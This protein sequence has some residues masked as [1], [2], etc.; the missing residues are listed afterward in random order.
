MDACAVRN[1][2]FRQ[3]TQRCT[4]DKVQVDSSIVARGRGLFAITT[5]HAGDT[6]FEEYPIGGTAIPYFEKRES[7]CANCVRPLGTQRF[8]CSLN[9]DES[10][11][12]S[13]CR[14]WAVGLYHSEFCAARSPDYLRFATLARENHNE[15]Y[16]VA[17]RLL[18]MLPTAP[19]LHH[20]ECP[21]WTSLDNDSA[22]SD[23]ERETELMAGILT[24]IIGSLDNISEFTTILSKTVGMLR[25][26]VMSIKYGDED[27]GFAL[28]STQSFMNHSDNP[29]CQ[30][31]TMSSSSRPD[32]PC[33]CAIDALREIVAG[34]ELTVDY[35][36][37]LKPDERERVLLYQYGID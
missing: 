23:L 5:V 16:I 30:C 17:A 14:D 9:C 32:N 11:C 8:T 27:L 25:V 28:Y 31:V 18:K 12:S 6:I 29:N 19:W 2:I 3:L 24:G 13:E 10:F 26:N 34:E 37:H 21:E 15:Y 4:S 1:A 20:Y 22:K 33:L 35:V 7:C 36:G